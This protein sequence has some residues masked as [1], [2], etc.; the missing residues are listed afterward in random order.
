MNFRQFI[1][2]KRIERKRS[3]RDDARDF[4]KTVS[5]L[6]IMETGKQ[7]VSDDYREFLANKYDIDL[8]ELTSYL[9]KKIST[10]YYSTGDE[11]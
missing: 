1:K 7:P 10:V 8:E 2:L 9:V 11:K 6:S 3:L 4:G 5:Y